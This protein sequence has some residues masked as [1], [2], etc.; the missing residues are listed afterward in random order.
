MRRYHTSQCSA[1]YFAGNTVVSMADLVGIS[2]RDRCRW[3][4]RRV[5]VVCRKGV[6]GRGAGGGVSLSHSVCL[7]SD[8][9]TSYLHGHWFNTVTPVHR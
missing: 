6:G 7:H 3:F 2:L 9:T 5:L 1:L 8:Y 4:V